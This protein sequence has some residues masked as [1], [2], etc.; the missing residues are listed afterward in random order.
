MI[1]VIL[2]QISESME[3]QTDGSNKKSVEILLSFLH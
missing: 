1:I 3:K 2:S